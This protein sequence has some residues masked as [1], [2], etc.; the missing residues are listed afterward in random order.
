MNFQLL[1]DLKESIHSLK[2][3]VSL[4]K[5][6]GIEGLRYIK[7]LVKITFDDTN[8]LNRLSSRGKI[9]IAVSPGLALWFN[10]SS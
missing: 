2:W 5:Y 9:L 8:S 4:Q 7:I 1:S 10:L 3:K 6:V